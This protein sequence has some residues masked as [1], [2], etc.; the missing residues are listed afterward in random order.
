M[1]DA[2]AGTAAK[3][4]RY[5]YQIAWHILYDAGDAEES[6]NHTWL[7]A[8]QTI[9]PH[10]PSI[11]SAFLGKIIRRLSIDKYRSRT[12]GKRGG[13]EFVLA[14]EELDECVTA[15]FDVQMSPLDGNKLPLNLYFLY[16]IT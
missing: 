5:C 10:R 6:V 9:P 1:E 12:A 4:G 14:L 16:A 2:V 3:Y 7:S 15:D 13:G 8:W 11:L